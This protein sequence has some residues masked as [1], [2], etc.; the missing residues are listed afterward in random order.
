MVTHTKSRYTKIKWRVMPHCLSLVGCRTCSCQLAGSTRM[1]G[2]QLEKP[3]GRWA[4]AYSPLLDCLLPSVLDT[5][6]ALFPNLA[7]DCFFLSPV[8]FKLNAISSV[9]DYCHWLAY[10]VIYICLKTSIFK[11]IPNQLSCIYMW[12][13][14]ILPRLQGDLTSERSLERNNL[15]S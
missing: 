9:M 3:N 12:S 4:D 6:F 15:P 13:P 1:G 14:G 10:G 7:I 11:S 8:G 2:E 5:K